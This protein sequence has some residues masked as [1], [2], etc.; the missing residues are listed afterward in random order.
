MDSISVK[1][2]GHYAQQ[3]NNGR[4]SYYDYGNEENMKLYGSEHAPDYNLSAISVPVG[5]FF[6]QNDLLGTT[7]VSYLSAKILKL[8]IIPFME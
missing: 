7:K 8:P 2:V 6:G 5:L 1:I 4:F 3:I